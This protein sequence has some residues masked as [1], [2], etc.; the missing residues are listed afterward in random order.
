MCRQ[1]ICYIYI[2]Y[3]I[4]RTY[5]IFLSYLIQ[6]LYNVQRGNVLPYIHPFSVAAYPAGGVAGGAGAYS[7][8]LRAKAGST[9]NKWPV[10]IAGANTKG[11][12][13]SNICML[14]KKGPREAPGP[15]RF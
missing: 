10:F 2:C 3:N 5:S 11:P 14:D 13:F 8:C 4:T 12:D 1:Y 9:L 7:S 15:G 6:F